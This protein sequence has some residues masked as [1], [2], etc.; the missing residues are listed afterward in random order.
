M[1]K[2][3]RGHLQKVLTAESL[4]ER[5]GGSKATD[6][7][8]WKRKQEEVDSLPLSSHR[9]SDNP[10]RASTAEFLGHPGL[11]S[12]RICVDATALLQQGAGIKTY[13]Y[14]WTRHLRAAAGSNEI[15]LFPWLDF[16]REC[17]LDRSVIGPVGTALRVAGVFGLNNR[18]GRA[19]GVRPL[20]SMA[21]RLD[22][23]HA[24]HQLLHPPR[25]T[26]L[27]ATIHDLTCWLMPEL[28][29]QA[30][31]RGH[32]EFA[33]QVLAPATAVIAIS[34]STRQDAIRILG[35]APEKI[36]V[37]YNG[38]APE[39]FG[40]A[41]RPP[42][43]LTK[44]YILFVGTI[45]PRKNVAGLLDAYEA[46]PRAEREA[47]DLVVAGPPGW[48]ADA[49]LQRLRKP[50]AGIHYLGYVQ[51]ID[52]P[53]LTAG[54][55]MLVYPSLYEGFGLPVA[56]AMAAGVPVITSNVSSLPEIAGDA[57]LLVDPRSVPALTAA[58]QILLG[59]ADLQRQLRERGIRRAEMFRWESCAIKS[60]EFFAAAAQRYNQ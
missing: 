55:V 27:T 1:S 29:T 58:M 21:R 36:T 40:A 59:S 35:L 32:R 6:R 2:R 51:E 39:Y 7:K 56:Q 45:E 25:G 60:W 5:L 28:H 54:A 43:G 20:D 19:L 16:P 42:A 52:L 14:Q 50:G 8:R 33:E 41:A 37:I 26:C 10:R 11:N 9:A 12:V 13:I 17:P 57:A 3:E 22:V 18:L 31:L 53:G 46:L 47:F 30:T 24:S 34:E 4:T 48:N 23:I 38:V 15:S 49:T 44:P